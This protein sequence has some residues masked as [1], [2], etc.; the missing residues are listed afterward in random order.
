MK[1]FIGALANDAVDHISRQIRVS[2]LKLA[3]DGA[4]KFGSSGTIMSP[5][6]N[7][8]VQLMTQF[9][10]SDPMPRFGM[11]GVDLT[12][13]LCCAVISVFFPLAGFLATSVSLS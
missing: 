9:A 1:L 6:I 10:A 2:A 12:Y 7:Q 4:E 3:I 5:Y 13:P 8:V 11:F